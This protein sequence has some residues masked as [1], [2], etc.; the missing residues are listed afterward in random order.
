MEDAWIGKVLF[1]GI[2]VATLFGFSTLLRAKSESARRLRVILGGA[3]ALALAWVVFMMLGPIG[4][5]IALA[6]GSA[7][8]WIAKGSKK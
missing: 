2:V 4:F 5:V 3:S 6:I 1:A 7:G 8:V